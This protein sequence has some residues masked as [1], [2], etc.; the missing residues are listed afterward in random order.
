MLILLGSYEDLGYEVFLV[1]LVVHILF[2]V[3]F[4]CLSAI[5]LDFS[6]EF[7]FLLAMSVLAWFFSFL[8]SSIFFKISTV[9]HFF[10]HFLIVFSKYFIC[11]NLNAFLDVVSSFICFISFHVVFILVI[12]SKFTLEIFFYLIVL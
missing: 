8:L 7:L 10:F 2:I 4:F 1:L 9:I 5:F 12:V 11:C 6:V 3:C